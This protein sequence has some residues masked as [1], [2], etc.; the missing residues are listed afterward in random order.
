[1]CEGE[2]YYN[3]LNRTPNEEIFNLFFGK[4]KP[5]L[6]KT[7]ISQFTHDSFMACDLSSGTL[8]GIV[9]EGNEVKLQRVNKKRGEE[10]NIRLRNV[11]DSDYIILNNICLGKEEEER[12]TSVQYFSNGIE[13]AKIN[14]I[15]RLIDGEVC[16]THKEKYVRQ[17]M[18]VV[19]ESRNF[20]NKTQEVVLPLYGRKINERE[21]SRRRAMQY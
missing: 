20:D 12:K 7:T 2:F 5:F 4:M 1:M 6:G 21:F 18:N 15:T 9:I 8:F 16:D 14:Q 11:N 10:I 19:K 13:M 17:D 3:L